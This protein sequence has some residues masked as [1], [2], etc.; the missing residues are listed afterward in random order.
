M[1]IVSRYFYNAGGDD[2]FPVFSCAD[3][4][5]SVVLSSTEQYP[6]ILLVESL[7]HNLTVGSNVGVVDVA[8]AES[9]DEIRPLRG[10]QRHLTAANRAF[11]DGGFRPVFMVKGRG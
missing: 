7:Q 3:L 1:S 9:E 10:V 4:Q 6:Y 8:V 2:I 11:V 5:T